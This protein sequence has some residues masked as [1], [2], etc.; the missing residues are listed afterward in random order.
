[1]RESVG[2]VPR[3]V[4]SPYNSLPMPGAADRNKDV[5]RGPGGRASRNGRLN[6]RAVA[7][8]LESYGL[9]PLE[10]I[11]KALTNREPV[12]D[13]N[14]EP[15]TDE[16]GNV[17]LRRRRIRDRNGELVEAPEMAEGDKLKTLVEL[18]QYSR[19]KLK[20]VE[21]RNTEPELTDE[22]IDRRLEALMT[23]QGIPR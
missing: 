6:L 3:L 19:P 2:D 7:D 10:E 11:A 18:A 20:A 16:H 14:G 1:M 9:D 23:K 8:V 21:V 22:Q 15:V 5:W 13:E 17:Q 12:L 4:T